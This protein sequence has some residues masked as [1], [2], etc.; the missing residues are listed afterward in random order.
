MEKYPAGVDH[1][2]GK[3]GAFLAGMEGG[4]ETEKK[5]DGKDEDAERDGPVSPI[6]G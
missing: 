2:K 5:T 6:G 3:R 1:W 4:N